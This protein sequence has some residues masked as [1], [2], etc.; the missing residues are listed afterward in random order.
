MAFTLPKVVSTP[1]YMATVLTRI[2]HR[3]RRTDGKDKR[4]CTMQ[5]LMESWYSTPCGYMTKN[6]DEVV[7]PNGSSTKSHFVSLNTTHRYNPKLNNA[8]GWEVSWD[9]ERRNGARDLFYLED[10]TWHYLG[11]YE[12]VGQAILPSGEIRGLLH[13]VGLSIP[14]AH[15]G[16]IHC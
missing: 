14:Y 6:R 2:T 16:I 10:R 15:A 9:I 5:Q 7:W 3:L 8:G 1:I 13:S 11:T 12:F 4:S